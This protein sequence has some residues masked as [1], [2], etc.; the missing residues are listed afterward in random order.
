MEF[1]QFLSLV[2]AWADEGKEANL[3]SKCAQAHNYLPRHLMKLCHIPPRKSLGCL[4]E[5][6]AEISP[7]QACLFIYFHFETFTFP[8]SLLR[9]ASCIM[10]G[11]SRCFITRYLPAAGAAWRSFSLFGL[12]ASFIFLSFLMWAEPGRLHY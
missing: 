3:S 7:G 12:Q 9:F 2:P 10:N 6:F 4:F 11:D 8:G 5:P 1:K